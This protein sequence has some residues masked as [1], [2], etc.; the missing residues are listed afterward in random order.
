M[1]E[2]IGCRMEKMDPVLLHVVLLISLTDPLWD[3]NQDA[4][5][6]GGTPIFFVT[7]CRH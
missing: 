6:G 7:Q 5:C 3:A 2:Q 4:F 1:D